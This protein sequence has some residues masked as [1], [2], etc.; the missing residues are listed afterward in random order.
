MNI[1]HAPLRALFDILLFPF[2]T[3]PPLAGLAAVSLATGVAM[4]LV[5]KATSNQRRLEAIK[6]QIHAGLFEIRLFND[7]LRAILRA[8]FEILRH[9]MTYLRLTAV[10]MLWMIV[11]LFFLIAQLQFHY[12]YGGLEPERTSILKVRLAGGWERDPSRLA[13]GSSGRPAIE[14]EA[15]AGLVIERPGVWMP[16]LNEMNWLLRPTAPG[17]YEISIR[18]GDEIATKTAHVSGDVVRRSPARVSGFLDQL[19]YPA[20]APLPAGSPLDSIHV[21]YPDRGVNVL[22]WSIHWLIAFFVL[23]LVFA[24]LLRNRLGVTI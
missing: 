24:F 2:R 15:P 22:G 20:E 19:I 13:P 12:G 6:R 8:Q 10:P 16:A 23:T 21:V 7:D 1:V 5:F 4:L 18:L 3:L 14:V 11:P 9:N 17:D